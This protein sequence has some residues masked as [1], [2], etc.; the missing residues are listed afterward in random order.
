M[1]LWRVISNDW[2]YAVLF[3]TSY[4]LHAGRTVDK[5]FVNRHAKVFERVDDVVRVTFAY[6]RRVVEAVSVHGVLLCRYLALVEEIHE[7]SSPPGV[8]T[9]TTV[10]F[11]TIPDKSP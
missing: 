9:P 10:G 7:K 1:R 2:F 5:N 3:Q 4:E 6:E 11:R 8:C